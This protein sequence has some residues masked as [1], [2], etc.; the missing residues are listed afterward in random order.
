M[1]IE[2]IASFIKEKAVKMKKS[3]GGDEHKKKTKSVRFIP[4]FLVVFLVEFGNFISNKLGIALKP[5]G[6]EKHSFGAA[7]LTSLGMLGFED[8]IAPFSG[9]R[10]F[11]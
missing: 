10:C 6:L 7:C 9:T 1:S 11:I 8:A 4:A 2:D 5:L 3:S